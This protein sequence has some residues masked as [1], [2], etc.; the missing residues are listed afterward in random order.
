MLASWCVWGNRHFDAGPLSTA[1]A[2]CFTQ[3]L[4]HALSLPNPIHST[5]KTSQFSFAS[6]IMPWCKKMLGHFSFIDVTSVTTIDQLIDL[7]KQI[8]IIYE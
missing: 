1:L 6:I 2:A 8:L 7:T 3:Q 4:L 5:F